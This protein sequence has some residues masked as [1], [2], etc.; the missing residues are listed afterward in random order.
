V[1]RVFWFLGF[2]I[3]IQFSS[4][5]VMAARPFVTDDPGTVELGR[6]E[7]EVAPDYWKDKSTI[8]LCFKHGLTERME[9]GIVMGRCALPRNERGYQ[10]AELGFKFAL[11]PD[12]LAASF[13]GM[14]NNP[15]Y[16][17]ALILGKTSGIFTVNA[18]LGCAMTSGT[19]DAEVMYGLSGIATFGRFETGVEID[20]ARESLNWWQIGAKCFVTDWCSIDAGI[21]GDFKDDVTM[22][23]TTGLW[24]AFP[25]S[26]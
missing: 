20:G 24:F 15:E 23:A 7:L 25:S 8:E 6:F 13:T 14:F 22:N 4:T 9:I 5:R 21:G 26:K 2:S 19:D 17:F 3:V 18:N 1:K 10:D 11:I 16:G 12:L